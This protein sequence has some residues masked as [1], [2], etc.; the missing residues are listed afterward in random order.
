M[1]P[2][3]D[4]VHAEQHDAEKSR[5]QKEGGHH[6]IGQEHAG[7]R[8]GLA[9]K[10]RPVRAEFIGHDQSGDDTH[11]KDDRKRLDPV[12]VQVKKNLAVGLQPQPLQNGEIG[13][14]PDR[15]SRKDNMDAHGKGE[16]KARKNQRKIMSSVHLYFPKGGT[17]AFPPHDSHRKSIPWRAFRPRMPPRPYPACQ[18]CP[19]CPRPLLG[20]PAAMRPRP[21]AYN[22]MHAGYHGDGFVMGPVIFLSALSCHG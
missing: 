11:A 18:T 3:P 9:G 16:L 2:T 13:R 1:Q 20:W 12:T 22:I 10:D 14:Q 7:N 15:E 6:L 17:L 4:P 21:S 8:S 19:G 5:L